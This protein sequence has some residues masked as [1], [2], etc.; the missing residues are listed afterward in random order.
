MRRLAPRLWSGE[1][2]SNAGMFELWV[3]SELT[4]DG[5]R[6]PPDVGMAVIA[7]RC[8]LAGTIGAMRWARTGS[9]VQNA[10]QTLT[11][12]RIR[13]EPIPRTYN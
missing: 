3:P 11:P 8:R 2:F 10:Y 4:L 9:G 13:A 6:V 12:V 5:E 1:G 7:G